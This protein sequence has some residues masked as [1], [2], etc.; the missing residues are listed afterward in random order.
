MCDTTTTVT[1]FQYQWLTNNQQKQLTQFIPN[2]TNKC[3]SGCNLLNGNIHPY[4]L[5]P[6]YSLTQCSWPVPF[7][8]PL[9]LPLGMITCKNKGNEVRQKQCLSNHYLTHCE[10]QKWGSGA[11]TGY[12]SFQNLHNHIIYTHI[13]STDTSISQI[14]KI[15]VIDTVPSLKSE[16]MKRDHSKMWKISLVPLQSEEPV[17]LTY[18]FAQIDGYVGRRY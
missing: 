10:T 16:S 12:H 15:N 6:A 18:R 3:G 17:Q 7:S 14:T 8:L 2:N 5:P 11:S 9:R 4:G 1:F 13:Y